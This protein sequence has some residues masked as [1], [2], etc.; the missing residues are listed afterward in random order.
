[1]QT[2][3]YQIVHISV[4]DKKTAEKIARGLVEKRLAACVQMISGVTSVYWWEE[5]TQKGEE[6]ILLAKTRAA[7]FP[8]LLL[9]VKENHPDQ[10][11]EV[12]A[13]P[14]AEANPAYI[15]WL[16]ANS[17]FTALPMHPEDM[18]KPPSRPQPPPEEK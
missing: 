1:M 12:I 3:N 16:G 10:V 15:D 6:V 8:E 7:L 13:M 17:T 2:I 14:I 11:P 9:F 5:K 4:P 18:P